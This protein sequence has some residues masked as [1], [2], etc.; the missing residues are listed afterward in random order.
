VKIKVT[1]DHKNGRSLEV[2]I[3][4]ARVD[5]FDHALIEYAKYLQWKYG[6]KP[7]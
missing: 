7:I 1:S 3:Y 5:I 4:D 6:K 2:E